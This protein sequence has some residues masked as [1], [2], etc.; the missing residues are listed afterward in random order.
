MRTGGTSRG[1]GPVQTVP[2]QLEDAAAQARRGALSSPGTKSARGATND[3]RFTPGWGAR[4]IDYLTGKSRAVEQSLAPNPLDLLRALDAAPEELKAAARRVRTPGVPTK[5]DAWLM[6][7]G[8]LAKSCEETPSCPRVPTVFARAFAAVLEDAFSRGLAPDVSQ[9]P[10]GSTFTGGAPLRGPD[11]E[12]R[13][14]H[15][16]ASAAKFGGEGAVLS[17]NGPVFSELALLPRRTV[18]APFLEPGGLFEVIRATLPDA[19][20]YLDIS[21][22]ALADP[23]SL[24]RFVQVFPSDEGE[25]IARLVKQRPPDTL[26]L[27]RALILG[28]DAHGRMTQALGAKRTWGVG[29]IRAGRWQKEVLPSPEKK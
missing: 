15:F 17:V 20:W 11:P 18:C 26:L 14:W 21:E 1:G 4:A 7:F 24:E 19:A 5:D 12:A 6:T 10:I 8:L 25:E 29:N 2:S 28:F 27:K 23:S 16:R 22:L 9:H 3:D 13:P